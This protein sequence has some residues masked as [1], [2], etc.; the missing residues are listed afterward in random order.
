[1]R[2]AKILATL[3]PASSSQT[4]IEAMI[5]AGINAVRINMSHGSQEEHAESINRARSAAQKL[6]KPL[7]VLVDLSGPKIR[8]RG[9]EDGLPVELHPGKQ[10]VITSRD[11]VGN[12]QEVS[13][14]FTQLPSVV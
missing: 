1:M 6:G 8:T 12:Q 2:R 3:G 11:I 10:F 4:A 7:S 14:N 5:E 9:L 13:T